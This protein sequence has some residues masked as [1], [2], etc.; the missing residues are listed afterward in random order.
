MKLFLLITL[1]GLLFGGCRSLPAGPVHVSDVGVLVREDVTIIDPV[2]G[3]VVDWSVFMEQICGVDVVLLGEQHDHAVGHAV[4]LAV[5]EDVMDNFPG[6]VLALEMLERDEQLRVDDYMEDF[7]DSETFSKIT[8]SGNWGAVGGWEA[9]YQPIIDAVKERGG[10]VIAANAPRRYVRLARLEG[11]E[12]IDQLPPARRCFIDY[13]KEFS[14]GRYRQR[15]FELGAHVEDGEDKPEIDVSTIDPDDPLLPSFKSMQA[16]DATMAQSVVNAG[17]SKDRKVILLVGH[18]HV[19]YDGGVVQEIRN[20][21]PSAD[22]LV[23]SIQREIPDE[24]WR[25]DP[26]IANFMVVENYNK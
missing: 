7:I 18:F 4:Q 8:H 1:V 13:P 11:Y 21:M 10:T 25:D 9:W 6:S 15:Y 3:S 14:S 5:V 20:R 23:A 12:R 16:W 19:D 2:S 26:P 22:I 24:E 17:P